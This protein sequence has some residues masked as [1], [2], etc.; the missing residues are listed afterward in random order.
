M[1]HRAQA[2]VEKL[3]DFD[4]T[5]YYGEQTQ[6]KL[7]ADAS[8]GRQLTRRRAGSAEETDPLPYPPKKSGETAANG[9][10]PSRAGPIALDAALLACKLNTLPMGGN[11]SRRRRRSC[12]VLGCCCISPSPYQALFISADQM[13][14]P[15]W[16]APFNCLCILTQ[17]S[18]CGEGQ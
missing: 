17:R 7:L 4:W 16:G 1:K 10:V 14:G 5:T 13:P 8:Y 18:F 6:E 3:A 15:T 9:Q 12:A 2:K 11:V